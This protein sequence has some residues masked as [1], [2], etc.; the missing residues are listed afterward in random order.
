MSTLIPSIT[1]MKFAT[2][3]SATNIELG[4]LI[5]FGKSLEIKRKYVSNLNDSLCFYRTI[6]F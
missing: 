5:N 4:L 2:H 3:L 1:I 6:Q